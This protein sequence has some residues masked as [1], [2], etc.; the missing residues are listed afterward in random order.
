MF[1]AKIDLENMEIHDKNHVIRN[2]HLPR[3]QL[4]FKHYFN[5]IN[6]KL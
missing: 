1:D 4:L 6:M 2:K 5:R 3:K